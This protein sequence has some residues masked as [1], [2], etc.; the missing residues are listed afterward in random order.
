[1][2]R[3]ESSN[4]ILQFAIENGMLDEASLLDKIEIDKRK[5]LLTKHKFKIWQGTNGK[6]Y[7]YIEDHD[8]KTNRKLVKR[9]SR[10]DI[11]SVAIEEVKRRTVDKITFK[12]WYDRSRTTMICILGT[13]T[14][15][16]IK[17]D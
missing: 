3:E 4:E 17:W 2:L 6:W 16:E 1:M 5:Q 11:E 12:S 10:S 14:R 15:K 13:T 9:S 8:K 7:T